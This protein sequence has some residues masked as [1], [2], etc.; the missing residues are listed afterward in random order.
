MFKEALV[1]FIAGG[2]QNAVAVKVNLLAIDAHIDAIPVDRSDLCTTV[3]LNVVLIH[4]V[5]QGGTRCRVVIRHNFVAGDHFKDAHSLPHLAQHP[6]CFHPNLTCTDNVDGVPNGKVCGMNHDLLR[7]KHIT[8]VNAADRRACGDTTDSKYHCIVALRLDQFIRLFRRYLRVE[9]HI[10]AAIA[11][12]LFI[13]I[14]KPLHTRFEIWC[15][16]CPQC[17]AQ[18]VASLKYRHCMP[19]IVG[20]DGRLHTTR[21]TANDHDLLRMVCLAQPIVVE[22]TQKAA[23]HRTYK[24]GAG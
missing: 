15:G 20:T 9:A 24:V 16:C 21:A 8:S 2:Q 5:E 22:L 4:F 23:I 12:F 11:D 18:T 3:N 19:T 17:A 14:Q 10:D 13:V 7:Y 6:S 1:P